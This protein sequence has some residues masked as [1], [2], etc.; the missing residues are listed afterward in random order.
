MLTTCDENP[1]KFYLVNFMPQNT[2]L[3]SL[4]F[5]DSKKHSRFAIFY[6]HKLSNEHFP[7]VKIS[8]NFIPHIIRAALIIEIK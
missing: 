7:L 8:F 3:R 5:I 2:I 1:Q 6:M 4:I